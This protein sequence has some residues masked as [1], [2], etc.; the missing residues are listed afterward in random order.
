MEVRQ[1]IRIKAGGK[2]P[3]IFGFNA[4]LSAGMA[5]LGEVRIM[6]VCVVATEAVVTHDLPPYSIAVGVP[7]KITGFRR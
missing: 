1:Y 3:T 4:G 2:R 7:A 6:D 5:F